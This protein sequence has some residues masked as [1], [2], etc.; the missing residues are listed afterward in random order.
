MT[1]L[2]YR[3]CRLTP[4]GFITAS[5]I[6]RREALVEILLADV[7]GFKGDT[8]AMACKLEHAINE[9]LEITLAVIKLSGILLTPFNNFF[10]LKCQILILEVLVMN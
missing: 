10:N 3:G 2:P 4:V 9:E 7:I 8:N 5:R 6:K 1:Y